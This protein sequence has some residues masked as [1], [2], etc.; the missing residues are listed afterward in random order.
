MHVA[1]LGWN[2]KQEWAFKM[3]S[4]CSSLCTS[5][6]SMLLFMWDMFFLDFACICIHSLLNIK[7]MYCN[8]STWSLLPSAGDHFY[9][10][11]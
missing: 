9:N 7:L 10:C 6:K 8:R 4:A 5:T 3:V 11:P 1:Q 2:M